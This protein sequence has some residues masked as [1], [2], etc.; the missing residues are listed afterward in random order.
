MATVNPFESDEVK[1]D[2]WEQ[3]LLAGFRL[4][5]EEHLPPYS[6]ELLDIYQ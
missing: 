5:D 4:P 6:P 1:G 3:G 2:V